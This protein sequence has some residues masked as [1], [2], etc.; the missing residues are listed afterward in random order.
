MINC[1][2]LTDFIKKYIESNPTIIYFGIGSMYYSNIPNENIV[3]NFIDNDWEYKNNQQFPPFLH[4]AKLKFFDKN[5]LIILIDPGFN[6]DHCPY[7]VSGSKNFLQNSWT[8]SKIFSNLYESSFG[9]SVITIKKYIQWNDKNTNP[10]YYNI[11]PLLTELCEFV[12]EPNID[13]LLFYHEFTG[14][15]VCQLEILIKKTTN[16]DPNKICIDITRGADLSCYFNLTNPENYPVIKINETDTKLKYLNPCKLSIL[17]MSTIILK[18]KKFSFDFSQN[19]SIDNNINNNSNSSPT[20]FDQYKTNYLID[21]PDELILFFQ[22]HKLDLLNTK[23]VSNTIITTIRQFYT[24]GNYKLF[25]TKMWTVSSFDL[26]SI[27]IPLVDFT[28]VNGLLEIFDT[29][30]LTWNEKDDDFMNEQKY[31][32]NINITKELIISE[33]YSLLEISMQF[34]LSKYPIEPDQI[35][36]FMNEIKQLENKYQMNNFMEN[37]VNSI[38]L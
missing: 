38:I 18:Y 30:N 24:I 7:L 29:I 22:I 6:D 17:E 35:V 5:I 20:L 13:S 12:S 28:E 36:N 2:D 15:N 10:E 33:L 25:G 34:I 16:Y 23:L 9:I 1:D 26:L 37:F 21:K 31:L 4:D 14:S 3:G 19:N 27:Q 8:K 32:E 11:K